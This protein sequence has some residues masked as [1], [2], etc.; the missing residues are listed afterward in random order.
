MGCLSCQDDYEEE[1][2]AYAGYAMHGE[3]SEQYQE[4]R[5]NR[6]AM[7]SELVKLHV[8][9]K[10]FFCIRFGLHYK[11]NYTKVLICHLLFIRHQNTKHKIHTLETCAGFI[12]SQTCFMSCDFQPFDSYMAATTL[13]CKGYSHN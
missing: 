7:L 13:A 6:I 12:C 5:E 10:N 1:E 2:R 8:S 3:A 9:K 4:I 11:I